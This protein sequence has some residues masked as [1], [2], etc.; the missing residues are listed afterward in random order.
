MIDKSKFE[1]EIEKI[2]DFKTDTKET[3]KVQS[4]V[5]I[6]RKVKRKAIKNNAKEIRN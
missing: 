3:I 5:N 2:K 4:N 1:R 6:I